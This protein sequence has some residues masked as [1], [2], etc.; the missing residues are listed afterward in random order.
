[1]LCYF[2]LVPYWICEQTSF[3]LG[4]YKA[5]T[6]SLLFSLVDLKTLYFAFRVLLRD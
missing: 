1:M 4:L 5:R 6:Y 3:V 2:A